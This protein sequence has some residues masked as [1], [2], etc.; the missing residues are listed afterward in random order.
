MGREKE[1][2]IVRESARN[3]GRASKVIFVGSVGVPS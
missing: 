3:V 1:E 2:A